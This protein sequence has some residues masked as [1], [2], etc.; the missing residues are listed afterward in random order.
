MATPTDA[1]FT[2]DI[3]MLLTIVRDKFGLARD[4]FGILSWEGTPPEPVMQIIRQGII[5]ALYTYI[6]LRERTW[7][8]QKVKLDLAAMDSL[9]NA[10]LEDVVLYDSP[11]EI[12]RPTK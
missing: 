9:L 4:S 2:A 8:K 11:D 12:G 5:Q 10:A 6:S 3:K 7:T 1:E